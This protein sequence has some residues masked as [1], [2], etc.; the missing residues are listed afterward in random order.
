MS[1]EFTEQDIHL[2]LDGELPSEERPAFERWLEAHPDMKAL[3]R[4]FEADRT[5]LQETLAPILHERPPQ[6]LAAAGRP[7]EASA[8][9]PWLRT[10]AAVLLLAIGGTGGYA[11]GTGGWLAPQPAAAEIGSRA[12]AA[13]LIYAN[14]KRHVV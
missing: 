12:I 14:E 4:R 11:L 10:A 2:A 5:R 7:R 9:A 3:S 1:R 6:H 13:H 8:F